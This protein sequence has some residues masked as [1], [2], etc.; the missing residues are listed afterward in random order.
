[1]YVNPKKYS[2]IKKKYFGS[3][4]KKGFF[5]IIKKHKLLFNYET[6]EVMVFDYF[7]FAM[8][9]KHIK[10]LAEEHNEDW[11]LHYSVG[12]KYDNPY[13][14][15]LTLQQI[16]TNDFLIYIPQEAKQMLLPAFETKK[17][18]QKAHIEGTP[19]PNVTIRLFCKDCRKT[20]IIGEECI[21]LDIR[22]KYQGRFY[23]PTG[24]SIRRWLK[25]QN[26]HGAIIEANNLRVA[27]EQSGYNA[28]TKIEIPK[29]TAFLIK[30]LIE[31]YIRFTKNEGVSKHLRTTKNRSAGYIN[32]RIM[33]LGYMKEALKNA[34]ANLERFTPYQLTVNIAIKVYEDIVTLISPRTG[35][36][37]SP[38]TFNK[39]LGEITSFNLY[40]IKTKKFKIDNYFGNLK[41]KSTSDYKP[42]AIS[43]KEI[44][45]M[46]D[47]IEELKYTDYSHEYFNNLDLQYWLPNTFLLVLATNRRRE[48]LICAKWNDIYEEEGY[49]YIKIKDYKV[50]RQK[51]KD[52]F[53]DVLIT[54]ELK[55]I[56][57]AMGFEEQ[58]DTDEYIVFSERLQREL[59]IQG[60]LQKF[61][62]RTNLMSKL[63]R[64]FPVL[65]KL[66]GGKR[67]L[68]AKS[69]KKAGITVLSAVIN[70][71]EL[72]LKTGHRSASVVNGYYVDKKQRQEIMLEAR[73][74][75]SQNDSLIA[76]PN[77]QT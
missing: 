60:I 10:M 12:M 75:N 28:K 47:K 5:E 48:D 22:K 24:D 36:I 14:R 31:E 57:N 29:K 9:Y 39:I 65:Y 76:N 32:E 19:V 53:V 35:K 59:M 46:L 26:Q 1:M 58:R 68:K 11:F 30:D 74:K 17:S 37:Y 49:E 44:N 64:S 2:E 40:L 61:N 42:V 38:F 15:S 7:D 69:L 16:L 43:K 52:I 33:Y 21:H 8:N 73:L 66:S 67:D 25:A 45:A 20:L 6:N 62:G 72:H 55:I 34:G 18:S 3:L 50:S 13:I 4:T 51:D 56:F 63:S 23:T 70:R 41:R 27:F 54:P 71:K 77:D